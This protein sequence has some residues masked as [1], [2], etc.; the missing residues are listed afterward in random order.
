VETDAGSVMRELLVARGQ[1]TDLFDGG[2]YWYV[3]WLGEPPDTGHRTQVVEVPPPDEWS[4]F[5]EDL[6]TWMPLWRWGDLTLLPETGPWSWNSLHPDLVSMLLRQRAEIEGATTATSAATL[7]HST[8]GFIELALRYLIEMRVGD[9]ATR[10][11]PSV[12]PTAREQ[13]EKALARGGRQ[14]V[15]GH[16]NFI[17][18]KQVIDAEWPAFAPVFDADFDRK[19]F[20]R[21]LD[22][23]NDIRNRTAHPSKLIRVTS[24]DLALLN[25]VSSQLDNAIERAENLSKG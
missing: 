20:F 8:L 4:D 1:V 24:E 23:A 25:A 15:L 17:N 13:A 16:L 3:G 12:R 2:T 11:L 6:M 7:A 5:A 22:H 19:R 18:F 10:I 14:S 9:D 21:E